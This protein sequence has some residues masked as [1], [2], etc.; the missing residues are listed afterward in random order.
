MSYISQPTSKTSTSVKLDHVWK[1]FH[2]QKQRTFKELLPALI[3]GE[4]AIDS[5]WALSD[6]SASI[7]QGET[8]AII[9]K[10]GSGKS[11][12]LKMIA[13]V[14]RPTQGSI[15]VKG[16]IAPLIELG[17]GFH[18]ELS[19]TEN[20]FLN[21]IILGMTRREVE[22]K[23]DQIVNFAE[24][25]DF[26]DQ[27]VK[28]YSSGM[29]LRLAF[30]VAVHTNPDVLLVDEIL[31]VGDEVFQKKCLQRIH[32]FIEAKKTIVLVSHDLDVIKAMATQA[33]ILKQGKVVFHGT[34]AQAIQHY[35]SEV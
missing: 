33:M 7:N 28:H 34:P 35:R 15:A 6:V 4:K 8:F 30:A 1:R 23:F 14:S 12:L 2:K 29:Y 21:G 27:P 31:S 13:G 25:W 18:P 16:R 22:A 19:G 9:G 5:F 11:T 10:N 32:E 26:I 20:I 3:K 17:A 24:L